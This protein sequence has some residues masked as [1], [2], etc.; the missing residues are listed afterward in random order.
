MEVRKGIVLL[1]YKILKM[2]AFTSFLYEMIILFALSITP[3]CEFSAFYLVSERKAFACKIL[4]ILLLN[5]KRATVILIKF[6]PFND[7]KFSAP[8]LLLY[9]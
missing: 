5:N 6:L 1:Q 9:N 8:N 2:A 3:D 4:C 7:S